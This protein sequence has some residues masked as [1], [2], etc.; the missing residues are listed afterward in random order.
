[1]LSKKILDSKK[2]EMPQIPVGKAVEKALEAKDLSS[3]AKEYFEKNYKGW[4]YEKGVVII[5]NDKVSKY[6]IVIKVNNTIY[7]IT[8]DAEWNFVEARKG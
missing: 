5:V 2:F 7:Y 8:F 1:M 4:T 6:L 3:K